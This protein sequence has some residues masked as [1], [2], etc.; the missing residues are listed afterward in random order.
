MAFSQEQG[1]LNNCPQQQFYQE[2]TDTGVKICLTEKQN[3]DSEWGE[4]TCVIE[5]ALILENKCECKAGS[6]WYE[7][8]RTCVQCNASLD[9]KY[10]NP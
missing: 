10:F 5:D 6:Q 7:P 9:D 1:C 8:T 3:K 4:A 2:F